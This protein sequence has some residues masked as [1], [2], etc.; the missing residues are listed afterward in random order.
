[1]KGA[2]EG[3]FVNKV[4][5]FF[6]CLLRFHRSCTL[7]G[8]DFIGLKCKIYIWCDTCNPK[9]LEDIKTFLIK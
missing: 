8:A 1:M 9:I 2:I 4:K 5:M 7:T 6:H 3:T